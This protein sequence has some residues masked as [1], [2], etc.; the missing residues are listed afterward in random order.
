MSRPKS[1]TE[2]AAGYLL[3]SPALAVML[4]GVGVPMVL[5]VVSSFWTQ[6]YVSIDHA[7]TLANYLKFFE[8]PLYATLLARSLGVS[9]ATTIAS[10]VL[11]YPMAYLIAFHGGKHRA[12]WLV[13]V[14]V[15]FWTSYL[16]RIFAWKVILG[17]NGVINSGL[18]QLGL[19]D[20]PLGILLYNPLAVIITLTQSWLPFVMLPIYV[21]LAKIE[22]SLREAAADLGDGAFHRFTRVIWPLSIPGVISAAL[23]VFIPTVG[24]YV[25]PALVGGIS[26]TLIG[27]V[28]QGQFG[29]AN[30][31]PMGAALSVMMMITVTA[32]AV[33]IQ[34]SLARARWVR[35]GARVRS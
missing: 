11:A 20:Q 1:L 15:P 18:L 29:R 22:P 2:V 5:L 27:N 32:A 21:S 23:L 7:P 3:L 10:V 25:T 14:A 17:Y 8:R 12:T 35:A 26:G 28:I 24:D 9:L 34:V 6:N 4:L 16:L 31:W 30:N 33:I 19:I 13:V